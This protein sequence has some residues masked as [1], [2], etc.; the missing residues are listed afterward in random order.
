MRNARLGALGDQ[1]EDGGASG[2]AAGAGGSGHGDEGQEGL[3]N[4]AS[5]AEGRVDEVEEVGFRVG[6]VEVH[7]LGRVH[8][9]AAADG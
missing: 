2:L 8:D 9:G 5:F 7:Q 4:W 6:V 3:V 1:V